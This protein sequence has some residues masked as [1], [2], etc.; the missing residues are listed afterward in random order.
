MIEI[1]PMALLIAVLVS[2]A[3][4]IH[5]VQS[6]EPKKALPLSRYLLTGTGIA[7]LA[8]VPGTIIGIAAACFPA[9]A[10]NLCGLVGVFGIGPVFS[11]IAIVSYA[12]FQVHGARRAT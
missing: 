11:A 2:A 12:R 7:V 10:G 6:P 1:G 5:Y 4:Y 8:Y 3:Y 9:N